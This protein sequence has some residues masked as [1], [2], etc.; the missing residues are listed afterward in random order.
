MDCIVTYV[1]VFTVTEVSPPA[2][3][4]LIELLDAPQ[5]S[6][7]PSTI[8]PKSCAF[9]RV[10]IVTYSITFDMAGDEYPPAIMP[11]VESE[12]AILEVLVIA[13]SPKSVAFPVVAHVI[14]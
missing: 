11:L 14:Y 7:I 8:S 4:P 12:V 3:T 6:Y 13:V 10:A 5:G 1:I 2:R 9:P